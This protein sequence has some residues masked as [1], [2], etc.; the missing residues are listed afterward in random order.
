[1]YFLKTVITKRHFKTPARR[2]PS[3]ERGF[4]LWKRMSN[5]ISCVIQSTIF[6]YLFSLRI[7]SLFQI[8]LFQVMQRHMH[9][10]CVK[11]CNCTGISHKN[12]CNNLHAKEKNCHKNDFPNSYMCTLKVKSS[13]TA[14][15]WTTLKLSLHLKG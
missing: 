12:D 8:T 11:R 15:H 14:L 13:S 6:N 5:S 9:L 10:Y 3:S 1:M 7:T 2:Y 4:D